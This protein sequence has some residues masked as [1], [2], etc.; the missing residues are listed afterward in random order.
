MSTTKQL[1][2]MTVEESLDAIP[3]VS[4]PIAVEKFL[5]DLGDK[6]DEAFPIAVN[7]V[8]KVDRRLDSKTFVMKQNQ[9]FMDWKMQY[10]KDH[11]GMVYSLPI[12]GEFLV[13]LSEMFQG[14]FMGR[15]NEIGELILSGARLLSHDPKLTAAALSGRGILEEIIE[16]AESNRGKLRECEEA[17]ED[18]ERMKPMIEGVEEAV[19]HKVHISSFRLMKGMLLVLRATLSEADKLLT[20]ISR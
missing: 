3:D 19:D 11:T 18:W 16:G 4:S 13:S 8:T 10:S 20:Q 15:C 6:A 1:W 17:I 12:P 2:D 14:A 5:M 7:G 9:R